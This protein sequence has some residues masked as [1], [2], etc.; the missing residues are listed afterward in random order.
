[1]AIY[2]SKE[3]VNINDPLCMPKT[4]QGIMEKQRQEWVRDGSPCGP[5]APSSHPSVSS[6]P[7]VPWL[8]F[9]DDWCEEFVSKR[10][11]TLLILGGVIGLI[12]GIAHHATLMFTALCVPFGIVGMVL[13]IGLLPRA[14]KVVLVALMLGLVAGIIFLVRAAYH[15]F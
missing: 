6:E 2:P 9:V 1:M 12:L 11:K 5:R 7:R 4:V 15:Y 14:I 3:R 8:P 13:F 10:K